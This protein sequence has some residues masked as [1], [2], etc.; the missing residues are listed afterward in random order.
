MGK[1]LVRH[2]VTDSTRKQVEAL[3]SF[4]ITQVDIATYLGI[5]H[6]TLSRRYKAEL[7]TG[8]TKAI[9]KVASVLFYKATVEKDMTAVIFFLKT[10]GRWREKDREEDGAKDSLVQKLIDKL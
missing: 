7:E 10:R 1:K 8:L 9:A 2:E 3:V 6:D 4:G 5:S